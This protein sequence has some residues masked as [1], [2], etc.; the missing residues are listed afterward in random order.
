MRCSLLAVPAPRWLLA[1]HHGREA[2]KALLVARRRDPAHR[3][4]LRRRLAQLRRLH[5]VGDEYGMTPQQVAETFTPWE[6]AEAVA[7][8]NERRSKPPKQPQQP[9]SRVPRFAL[10]R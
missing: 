5:A 3:R 8:I 1:W 9:T 6:I 10:P 7:E 4:Q 2:H